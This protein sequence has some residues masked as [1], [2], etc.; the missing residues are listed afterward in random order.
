MT[1]RL[2]LLDDHPA[3]RESVA[4]F[5]RRDHYEVH[6]VGDGDEAANLLGRSHFDLVITDGDHPGM[7]GDQIARLSERCIVLTGSRRED[8]VH[9]SV[10][11]E[12]LLE[13]VKQVLAN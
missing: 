3:F 10:P 7:P 11:I 1:H 12:G 9:K 4:W 13:H 8:S 6:A 5:L 2:L